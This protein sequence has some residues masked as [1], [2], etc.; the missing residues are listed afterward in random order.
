MQEMMIFYEKFRQNNNKDFDKVFES[1]F[2]PYVL[3]LDSSVKKAD[4][5]NHL[6]KRWSDIEDPQKIIEDL[7]TYQDI[8]IDFPFFYWN[9]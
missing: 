4:A 6:R 5:F 1:Y 8:F 9:I 7:A 3:T 2:F